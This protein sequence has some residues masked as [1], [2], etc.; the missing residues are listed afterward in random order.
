MAVKRRRKVRKE[1]YI[2][3]VYEKWR[4]NMIKMELERNENVN[5]D[6]KGVDNK[7]KLKMEK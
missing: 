1:K 6:R 3:E 2:G 7:N 5:K 4:N